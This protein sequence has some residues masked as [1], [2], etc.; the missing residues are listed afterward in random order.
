MRERTEIITTTTHNVTKTTVEIKEILTRITHLPTL[1][2]VITLTITIQM[3]MT[4]TYPLN[5][6]TN[7]ITI[8]LSQSVTPT[9][10]ISKIQTSP[11][12]TMT[13]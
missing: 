1:K 3:T 10:K 4:I 9:L 5:N 12:M 7:T 6:L 13:I 8:N 11:S 2:R